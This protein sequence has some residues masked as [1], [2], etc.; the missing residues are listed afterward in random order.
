MCEFRTQD[1]RLKTPPLVSV[2]DGNLDEPFLN[3]VSDE[4]RAIVDVDFAHQVVFV[5]VDGFHADIQAYSDLFDGVTF[6][7]ELQNLTFS[8]RKP[9]V[10][11]LWSPRGVLHIPRH[12]FLQYHWTK[13]ALTLHHGLNRI[14]KL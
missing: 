12:N 10:A 7:Q 13:V 4:F 1:S 6:R 14:N 8:R 2:C 11:G 5:H 9:V 3:G